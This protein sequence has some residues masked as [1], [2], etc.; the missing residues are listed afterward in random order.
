MTALPTDCTSEVEVS[1]AAAAMA[2][3]RIAVQENRS[4]SSSRDR[5]RVQSASGGAK[6]LE[7]KKASVTT[8]AKD[9]AAIITRHI[10]DTKR[11]KK[12]IAKHS[13]SKGKTDMFASPPNPLKYTQRKQLTTDKE[14][15]SALVAKQL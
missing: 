8:A 11:E 13:P 10:D 4:P 5:T 7:T 6:E 15:P 9:R 12:A 14:C 3:L 2:C 1:V